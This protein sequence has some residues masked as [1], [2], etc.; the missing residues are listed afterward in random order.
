MS[1]GTAS[2]TLDTVKW[3]LTLAIFTSAVIANSYFVEVAF[4][5]RVLGVVFLFIL[6]LI[7]LATTTFGSNSI[8]LMRESRTEIRKVVWPTRLETT[9]T[10]LVV[11]VSIIVLVIFFWG[12]ES[13]LSYLTKLVLG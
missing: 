2:K 12:L 1:K 7:F 13:L 8:K 10:F 5:Y 3:L 4:L 9:Q 6:G 11:F